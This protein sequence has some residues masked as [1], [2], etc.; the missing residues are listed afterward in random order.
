[1]EIEW[2]LMLHDQGRNKMGN[3]VLLLLYRR[4]NLEDIAQGQRTA[5]AECAI[6]IEASHKLHIGNKSMRNQLKENIR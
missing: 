6:S 5:R 4:E 2:T 3:W 1:M